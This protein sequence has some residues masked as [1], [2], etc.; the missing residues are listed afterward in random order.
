MPSIVS[1]ITVPL[2]SLVDIAIVGHIGNASY[3][4]AISVGAMIFNVMYWVLAFL[5]MGTSGMTAQAYGAK[6]R[7]GINW[8]FKR[9]LSIG[10]FLGVAMLVCMLSIRSVAMI[11][12]QVGDSS[13]HLVSTYF[14]IGIFGAP[15]VL[16][17]FALNG[18]LVGMQ[19]TKTPMLV[20]V[21]QNIINIVFSLMFVFVL[22]MDIAGVALGTVLSQWIAF[23]MLYFSSRHLY[24]EDTQLGLRTILNSGKS[25]D[26]A[27]TYDANRMAAFFSTNRDIFFRTLCL[28]A[29]NLFFTSAGS[30]QGEVILAVNTL[31]MTLFTLFSYVMDGFAFAGEALA[32][33]FVG[34]EDRKSLGQLHRN[35]L[36][37]GGLFT[38]LFTMLYY[39]GGDGFLSLLTSDNTVIEASHDYSFFA[40]LIPVCGVLA[41]IY[42]G[43]FIGMTRTKEMFLSCFVGAIFFFG[44][45]YFFFSELGNIAL[46]IALLSYLAMR[47]VVLAV[48]FKLREINRQND[49]KTNF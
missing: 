11:L 39:L 42:D 8:L 49:I 34:A 26:E 48:A 14:N 35:L 32:G 37:W 31:I 27:T 45:Y 38:V 33:R 6:D 29:V 15:A 40:L 28:V 5:R 25:K 46:W 21:S 9:S 30:A 43:L 12:M 4:A 16:G 41:F 22:K 19:N 18:F 17:A 24:P 23:L 44:I 20:A 13:V 3:L 36:V 7:A 1:N 47:G 10:F 2:L